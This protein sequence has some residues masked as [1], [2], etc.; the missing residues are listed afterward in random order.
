[1]KTSLT[2]I[3]FIGLVVVTLLSTTWFESNHRCPVCRTKNK[4]QDIGSYGSYIYKWDSKFQYIF[5]PLTDDQVVYSCKKCHYST[6]MWDFDSLE[7]AKKPLVKAYLKEIKSAVK[8]KD[9]LDVPIT[10]RL[11]LAEGVYRVLGGDDF[12]WSQFYRVMGYHYDKIGN[13]IKARES[14]IKALEIAENMRL[15]TKNEGRLKEILLITGGMK[16]FLNERESAKNDFTTALKLT[17]K[18][19]NHNAERDANINEYLD[20]VLTE[21]LNK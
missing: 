20:E 19:D 14:R 15:D 8:A 6:Y 12:F 11:Q 18:S 16:Y 3:L 7:A 17:Y 9:Y 4:F 5:W 1:M 2:A 21:F 10:E 13:E